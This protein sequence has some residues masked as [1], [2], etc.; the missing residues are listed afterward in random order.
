MAVESSVLIGSFELV[1]D[2]LILVA[3]QAHF[4]PAGYWYLYDA[5]PTISLITKLQTEIAEEVPGATVYVRKD[6]KVH[7]NFNGVATPISIAAAVAAHLGFTGSPYASATSRTAERVSDLLWSPGWPETTTNSPVGVAGRKVYDRIF[8]SSPTGQTF[9]VTVHHSQ[10]H[11]D[12]SW[13]AVRQDRAWTVAE[14]PGEYVQFFEDIIVPG[15]RMKLYPLVLEDETSSAA[16]TW[17]TAL[18]PYVIPDPNYDWYERFVATSDSLG[19]NIDM[20]AML[21]SEYGDD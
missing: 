6:R 12:L 20:K 10:T 18:G 5:D 2:A 19:A 9:N 4:I 3:G 16:W 7:I 17:T 8:T 11:I 1:D 15:R 21:T 14:L 13:S